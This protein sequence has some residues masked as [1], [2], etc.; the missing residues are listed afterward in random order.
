MP[1]DTLSQALRRLTDS[2]LADSMAM[3][4]AQR[5]TLPRGLTDEN[6]PAVWA[7]VALRLR[8]LDGG[9]HRDRGNTGLT[10]LN[11]R[12]ATLLATVRAGALDAADAV[13]TYKQIRAAQLA[14]STTVV[15]S[16][17]QEVEVPGVHL[18]MPLLRLLQIGGVVSN[19]DDVW[20]DWRHSMRGHRWDAP[21]WEHNDHKP[22]EITATATNLRWLATSDARPWVPTLEQTARTVV[23]QM[24]TEEERL[25]GRPNQIVHP[26][27][28]GASRA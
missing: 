10:D 18:R 21:P 6:A 7:A 11:D 23:E 3:A 9:R 20:P 15:G 1:T 4:L 8:G 16:G 28:I 5:Q 12:L 17:N 26:T 25:A 22:L 24:H 27:E 19:V 13:P 14:L 2:A